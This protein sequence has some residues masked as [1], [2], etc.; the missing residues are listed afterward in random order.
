MKYGGY[1]L[2]AEQRVVV[3]L[4]WVRFPVLAHTDKKQ[5]FHPV[6]LLCSL[7]I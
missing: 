5:G 3:P 6:F 4:A 7:K 2:M 1:S